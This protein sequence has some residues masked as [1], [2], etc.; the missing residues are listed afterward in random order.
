MVECTAYLSVATAADMVGGERGPQD[1]PK[2]ETS[3]FILAEVPEFVWSMRRLRCTT[4][5]IVFPKPPR[6]RSK[7]RPGRHSPKGLSRRMSK[8][9]VGEKGSPGQT[10]W[11]K[12]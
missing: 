8:T 3:P 2:G 10:L 9:W 6:S 7:G 11:S 4:L 12:E 5:E 1:A